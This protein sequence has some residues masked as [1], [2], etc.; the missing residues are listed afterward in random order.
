ML[1]GSF[2]ITMLKHIHVYRSKLLTTTYY[3]TTKT[4]VESSAAVIYNK[5]RKNYNYLIGSTDFAGNTVPKFVNP[6]KTKTN[7]CTGE[8]MLPRLYYKWLEAYI[9]SHR[10][11][12]MNSWFKYF[13]EDLSVLTITHVRNAIVRAQQDNNIPLLQNLRVIY[14]KIMFV[15][16]KLPSSLKI[17]NSIFTQLAIVGKYPNADSTGEIP[18]HRDNKDIISCVV[19]FG[20][21][22][23]GSGS[24]IFHD[25]I[26]DKQQGNEIYSL[27]FKHGR[28][29]I[30]TYSEI[31]HEVTKWRGDRL[32][33]NFNI[34]AQIVDH[35]EVFGDYFYK[36]YE[37]KD[38]PC[39]LF[40]AS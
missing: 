31:L 17:Y 22:E 40:V 11:F 26:D 28:I 5:K 9:K 38:Y 12:E 4:L 24:T 10:C 20:T 6:L 8:S 33:M 29:Q 3:N 1:F 37:S 16:N 23:E 14:R 32:T 27:P 2:S 25:G 18:L 36:Q 34:K 19:T 30:G 7:T 15:L 13:V 21:V 39:E 35:F